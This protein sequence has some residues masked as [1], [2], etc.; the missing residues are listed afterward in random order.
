M[1]E[2]HPNPILYLNLTL[3]FIRPKN[4]TLRKVVLIQD[5]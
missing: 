4:H 3:L 1:N 2:E 5:M